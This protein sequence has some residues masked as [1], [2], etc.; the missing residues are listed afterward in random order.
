[1]SA[2]LDELR[3]LIAAEGPI[4]VE[5][6]MTLA[7]GHPRHGYYM[8]RDPF[9]LDGDFMTAPEI[10][11]MFGELIGLFAAQCW[12]DLGQ[13]QPQRLVE[14]G[15]GRGTLM[16]DALRA[17][18]AAPGFR[19]ALTV[20]LVETSPVL[21][22]AQE[23]MLAGAGVPIAWRSGIGDIAQVEGPIVALGNEFLDALP[24]RQYVRQGGAWHERLIGLDGDA[25]VFG[26]A[27]EPETSLLNHAPDGAVLEVALTAHRFVQA[28][29]ERMLHAGGVALFLDYGHVKSAY[30]D[31]LQAM[32]RHAFVDPLA[33]PG[34]ADL[35]AHVDFEALARTALAA[36]LTVH[37]P[38]EQGPFLQA[39]GLEA[40]ADQLIRGAKSPEQAEQVR[41]A[42]RRL[43]EMTRTGMGRLFKAVAFSAPGQPTPPGFDV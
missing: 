37:G 25:L 33:S 14:F 20:E 39:L 3:L 30:G 22:A 43:T 23:R 8:T 16:A 6:Y 24:I 36:G 42:E 9:G 4:T 27:P 11:Q 15:P 26:L 32:R 12:L 35:T 40:R 1:M 38:I 17:A 13:P 21:R 28:L 5:R 34:E 18:K 19:E 10:S 41:S 2:L 7:L 29:A 31:T